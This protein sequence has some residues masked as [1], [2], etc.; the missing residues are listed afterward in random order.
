MIEAEWPCVYEINKFIN[1]KTNQYSSIQELLDKNMNKFPTW[2]WNNSVIADLISWIK[3]YNANEEDEKKRINLFGI[4]CQQFKGSYVFLEQFL[5]NYDKDFYEIITKNIG[6]L[7]QF[8]TEHHYAHEVINGG[9]KKYINHIPLIM[10]ELLSTYQWEHVDKLINNNRE[11]YGKL[12]DIMTSEQNMEIIVNGEEY[13][14]KMLTE[15]RGSQASWN[16]RDQH[17]LTT[18]MRI[19]NRFQEISDEIP[20]ASSLGS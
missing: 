4:D 16:T 10:Q 1:K 17:M 18:I 2:M 9:M 12:I 3:E 13:F 6:F 19:R 7:K 15:P 11:D 20:K 8:N 5:K 14:R